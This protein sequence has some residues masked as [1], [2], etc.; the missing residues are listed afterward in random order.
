[1]GFFSTSLSYPLSFFQDERENDQALL[2]HLREKYKRITAVISHYG[3]C[4]VRIK[5]NSD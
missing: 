1:M 2:K 3:V 4:F 5:V